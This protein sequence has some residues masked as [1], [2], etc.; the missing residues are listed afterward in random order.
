MI[1]ENNNF[2]DALPRFVLASFYTYLSNICKL[3]CA[4]DI[5]LD[6][7]E[8]FLASLLMANDRYYPKKTGNILC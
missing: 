8:H 3:N 2:Y 5:H 4:F 6:E 7:V 1:T